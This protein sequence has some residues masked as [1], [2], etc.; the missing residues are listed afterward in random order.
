MNIAKV[1]IDLSLDKSFDY[2]IPDELQR[3]VHVGV[4]VHVP[5][6]RSK[7]RGYVLNIVAESEYDKPLKSILSIAERHCRIPEKLMELGRWMAEY[8]CCSREKAVRALLPGAVR[9]GKVKHKILR[10]FSVAT[11]CEAEKFVIEHTDCKRRAGQVSVV[12]YLLTAQS[13]AQEQLLRGAGVTMSPVNSLLKKNIISEEKRIVRRDPFADITVV[14]SQPLTPNPEQAKALQT[15]SGVLANPGDRH[16]VL[17]HG[18]TGSGKTEIYLQTIARILETGREAIVLVPEISLT[19]QTVQ[20]FRARFGDLVCVLHSRLTEGERFDEWSKINDG[21][22]KIVVGARSALFAPFRN[23]GLI[24]V[25]EEHESTYKQNE[26]PRYHARDLAVMRGK[27]ENAVV[28]LGSATPSFESYYNAKQGKYLLVELFK[29]VDN[30]SLPQVKLIDQRL[31]I[32]EPGHSN[33]FSPV[34]VNAIKDRL[35]AGEQ[36]ILFLNRRGYARQMMCDVC[37][38]VAQCHSCSIAYTYHKKRESL[39]CH[40]CG[41]V[42]RAYTRCPQCNSDKIRYSGSGTEKIESLAH[43]IFPTARIARMD[44]DT[45]RQ[46]SSYE[47]VLGHFKRGELDILIGTQM[48]A[49]GLHFPNVTLVG[50]LNADQGLYIPDFRS[51]ERTFQLL[52]Q[53]AGRA[54]RGDVSGEVLV[55]TYNP[56]NETIKYAV[57]HD[58]INFYKYD[59]AVREACHYPPDGHL[60]AV[61]FRSANLAECRQY[62]LDFMEYL[63]PLCQPGITVTE[64]APAPIERINGKYRYR[65]IFRGKKLHPLQQQLRRMLLQAKPVKGL[66][67]YVDVDAYSL[68]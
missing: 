19:P 56:D 28:L 45:M 50:V 18:V 6:G 31:G 9:S 49:K 42:I 39:A 38:F 15:I 37:G 5:F 66:D 59:M 36:T 43:G 2:L 58:F 48:I 8:Y 7:R 54:G 22:V 23:L 67:V 33:L 52:T 40:L 3:R 27:M 12:K 25:D 32:S 29:R 65:I 47:D 30:C 4:Q 1:I 11:P 53:V 41:D 46:A 26:A 10:L 44:S 61:F 16:V 57:R 24:V 60:T 68:M 34:L 51:G 64:P 21:L 14:R 35:N 13:V 17:I 20:R 62:A 63:R 55:Q